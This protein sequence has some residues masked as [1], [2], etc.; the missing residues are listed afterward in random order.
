MFFK[1]FASKNQL[2][3]LFVR[4][5]LVE[6]GFKGKFAISYCM[7]AKRSKRGEGCQKIPR[8]DK[9]SWERTML[10]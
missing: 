8:I 1:R 7:S 2:P 10:F 5:T 3:G 4:G 9:Q 6:N